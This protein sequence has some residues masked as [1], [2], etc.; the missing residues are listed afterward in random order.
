MEGYFVRTLGMH[1]VYNSAFMNMLKLEENTKYRQ[2][3]KNVLEFSPEVLQ[4]FVNFLNNPDEETAE[5]QFGKG[6]KYFGVTMLLVTN[7]GLPM[8]GH[9]QIEG[10][11]EKYGMEYRRAYRDEAVDTGLLERH[12]RELFPL[13][14]MRHVFSGATHFA[15]FDFI[16]DEG[17]VDE[18]VFAYS[19][20]S[21]GARGLI[22]YNNAYEASSGRIHHSTAINEGTA[23]APRLLHRSLVDALALNT[24][25]TCYYTY[26]DH[27][28]GL[29]YVVYAPDIARNG[30]HFDISGYQYYALIDWCEIQDF[31]NSWGR[32]HGLLAGQGVTSIHEAYQEMN[33]A[34]VLKPF[35][36]L[37]SVEMLATLCKPR[38]SVKHRQ[39]FGKAFKALLQAVADK[40]DR[41]Q[42]FDALVDTVTDEVQALRKFKRSLAQLELPREVHTYLLSDMPRKPAFPLDF[43][44]V[45][46]AWS[47]IR[48]LGQVA[49]PPVETL[50]CEPDTVQSK[51]AIESEEVVVFSTS[52]TTAAWMTEWYLLKPLKKVFFALSEDLWQAEM[53]ARLVRICVAFG[54]NVLALQEEVWSPLLTRNS[55]S[56]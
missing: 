54:K 30:L 24:A 38:L 31:D 40:I 48:K 17:G 12:E 52:D 8:F 14:A 5:A 11:T 25:A 2:T 50:L 39:D 32:L 10:Y 35:R 37:F 19:N 15:L 43:W 51:I 49:A 28:S 29:E 41:D 3:I 1:R 18:N 33:L 22:I 46:L 26:R 47:M 27:R 55:S 13:M 36:A 21:G 23:D 44:C 45:P 20:R 4:R 53:D 42:N 6:D 7:P 16:S 56:G 9:G 34:P